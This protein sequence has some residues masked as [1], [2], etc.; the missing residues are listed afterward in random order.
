MTSPPFKVLIAGCGS[1]AQHW[2]PAIQELGDITIVG[3]VDLDRDAAVIR[4]NEFKL[5]D[6]HINTELVPAL[7]ATRPDLF[8]NLT[9]PE[10]HAPLTILA[11]E[12]GC[13]VLTE[14]PLADSMPN[15]RR[16]IE[17]ARK[18]DRLLAVSQQRRYDP[19]LWRMIR[20]IESGVLGP[21]TTITNDFFVGPHFGGFRDIMEHPLLLDMAIHT[22]DAARAVLA[23]A[24]PGA[25]PQ[26]VTCHEW[27]PSGSWYRM[28]ASAHALFEMSGGQVLDYRGSWCSEGLPTSWESEW[29]VI[30][31]KGTF[32]WDGDQKYEAQVIKKTGSFISEFE[33]VP[34]PEIE[35][36]R[37]KDHHKGLIR[38][39]LD[40][41]S[42]G[43]T[44]PTAAEDNLKSLAMVFGAIQS[45]EQRRTIEIDPSVLLNTD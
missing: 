44:P 15:A 40:C 1:M 8:F 2:I 33:E 29:R 9:I 32:K 31:E 14:K 21:I 39:F 10:A 24:D 35:E 13:H 5:G 25:V 20:F 18:A 16:M 34:V 22:F 7:E 6:V 27:N 26:R 11:L 45:A 30:G 36:N 19:R 3:L 4:A 37:F 17:A 12:R 43:R 28:G 42:E 41:V 38:D 23:A